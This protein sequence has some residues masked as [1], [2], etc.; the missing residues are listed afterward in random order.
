MNI[1]INIP[2]EQKARFINTM[3]D[4]FNY[5]KRLLVDGAEIDNP[6]GRVAFAKRKSPRVFTE[7]IRQRERAEAA[8]AAEMAAEVDI[9][10]E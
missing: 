5:Q 9:T 6:E 8:L 7:M 4:H 1:I 2:E 10:A 3:C